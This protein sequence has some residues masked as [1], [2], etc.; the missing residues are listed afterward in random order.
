MI[1]LLLTI[2]LNVLL[3]VLF[4]YF[5]RWRIDNMQAIIFNYWVCVITGSIFA[6]H[7]PLTADSL[8]QPWFP[9]ALGLGA[10]FIG[11]FNLIAYCT[12]TEGITVT[13]VANKMSLVLPAALSVWL[14]GDHLSGG[15]ILGIILAFPAVYLVAKTAGAGNKPERKS[16]SSLF[17]TSVLFLGSGVL[18][19]AMKYAESRLPEDAAAQAAFSVHIFAVAGT[20][21]LGV[22]LYLLFTGSKTFA[23]RHLAGGILLGIPNFFSIYYFIRMLNSG[24]L[25]GAAAIPLNNIGILL[26]SALTALLLFREKLTAPRLAGIGLSLVVILLLALT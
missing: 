22:L 16:G 4:K 12:R 11:I 25:P 23:W 15:Q 8:Q 26:V 24:F 21:G 18:D 6:G 20:I 19:T 3:S 7:F 2:L 10:G 9:I 5:E 13:T 17:W 14:Y 1:Y